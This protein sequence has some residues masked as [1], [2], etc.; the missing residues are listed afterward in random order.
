METVQIGRLLMGTANE[1]KLKS[2]NGDFKPFQCRTKTFL[3]GKAILGLYLEGFS[4]PS[5]HA[6]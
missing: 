1:D 4:T 2:Q 6:Y 5:P 3:L